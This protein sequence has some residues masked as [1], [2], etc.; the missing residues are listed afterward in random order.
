MVEGSVEGGQS[1][2]AH[3]KSGLGGCRNFEWKAIA[4]FGEMLVIVTIN[5]RGG[6]GWIVTADHQ[7]D[8]LLPPSVKGWLPEDSLARLIGGLPPKAPPKIWTEADDMGQHK[9]K[10]PRLP[11]G[12]QRVSRQPRMIQDN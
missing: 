10:N 1:Y 5:K 3:A 11:S 8:R 4:G 12:E 7:T 6:N 9:T 2:C